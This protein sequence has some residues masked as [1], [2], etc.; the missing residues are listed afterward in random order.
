LAS[1]SGQEVPPLEGA[2]WR[3]EIVLRIEGEIFNQYIAN[4]RRTDQVNDILT[5]FVKSKGS[6]EVDATYTLLFEINDLGETS[7]VLK[8]DFKADQEILDENHRKFTEERQ[9]KRNRM[10]VQ[11]EVQL[12]MKKT[13]KVNFVR[14]QDYTNDIP[15]GSVS[16]TPS[17]RM[18]KRGTIA[19][20]G[21]FELM[22]N[23]N[24]EAV[25][26][27]ERSPPSEE[28]NRRQTVSNI[29]RSFVLPVTF[30]ATVK[31]RKDA[32]T[33]ELNVTVES[34]NPFS[35]EGNPP[36]LDLERQAQVEKEK[37]AAMSQEERETYLEEKDYHVEKEGPRSVEG[38]RE[39]FKSRLKGTGSF[40]VSPLFE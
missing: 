27:E 5:A 19:V 3:G 36:W 15:F 1:I 23:G 29:Q 35:R 11:E 4:Q 33:G 38:E 26:L 40:K 22:F 7:F 10:R 37:L 25:L 6:M 30:S 39:I 8:E 16:F 32:E 31:H 2:L 34:D 13:T 28:L 18:K 24:G 21:Q 14:E 20:S 12:S 9:V 17:G